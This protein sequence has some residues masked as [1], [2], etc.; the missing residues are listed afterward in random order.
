MTVRI[1]CA[2]RARNFAAVLALA[3]SCAAGSVMTIAATPAQADGPCTL[4][5]K[6]ISVS[7][8]QVHTS[9]SVHCAQQT[10][11]HVAICNNTRCYGIKYVTVAGGYN[12][13]MSTSTSCGNGS[14]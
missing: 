4:L 5:G 1:A 2:K 6:G 13:S 12:K 10:T 8:G 7:S 14:T 9:F 3:A 11:F